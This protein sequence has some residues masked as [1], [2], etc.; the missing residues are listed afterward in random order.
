MYY[1]F[2]NC[3]ITPQNSR[4]TAVNCPCRYGPQSISYL[5]SKSCDALPYRNTKKTK[6][7]PAGDINLQDSTKQRNT[8]SHW[9]CQ[10]R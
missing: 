4:G 6:S 10:N 2:V 7:S 5:V 3:L 8:T 9:E 1:W